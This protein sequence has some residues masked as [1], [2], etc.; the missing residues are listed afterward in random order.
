MEGEDLTIVSSGS[1]VS[2]ALE[3]ACKLKAE[4]IKARIVSLPCWS[5]F[6]KQDKEYKLSVLKSG[7]PILSLE[8]LSVCEQDGI[9]EQAHPQAYF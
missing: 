4:G 1:E 8:A 2:I 6:D 9:D 3:A 5:V 7:A